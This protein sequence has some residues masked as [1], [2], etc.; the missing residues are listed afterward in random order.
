M[1]CIYHLTFF[2]KTNALERN[3]KTLKYSYT[4]KIEKQTNAYCRQNPEV[5]QTSLMRQKREKM[6]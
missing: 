5:K 6:S 4:I 3:R 2:P 1:K